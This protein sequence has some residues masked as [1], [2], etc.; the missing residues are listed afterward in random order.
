MST[1]LPSLTQPQ[2]EAIFDF[3]LLGMYA[4]SALKLAENE[5]LYEIVS[6]LGWESYQDPSEYSDLAT[7]RVRKASE[8]DAGTREF[9]AALSLRL[10]GADAKTFALAVL[11]RLL[12]ADSQIDESEQSFHAAAKAAFGI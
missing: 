1:P 12:E 5:R 7:A 2:R 3:L 10:G 6:G 11:P 9:L 8:T 4:D